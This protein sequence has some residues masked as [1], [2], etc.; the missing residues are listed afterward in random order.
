MGETMHKTTVKH[1]NQSEQG[2]FIITI[3]QMEE[4]GCLGV[5]WLGQGLQIESARASGKQRN[6]TMDENMQ[7]CI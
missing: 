2:D 4:S 7:W 5:R 1:Q 3:K 6:S